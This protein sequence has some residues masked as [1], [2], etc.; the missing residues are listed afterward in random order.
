MFDVE[1]KLEVVIKYIRESRG[2]N[3]R[4][5]IIDIIKD[6]LNTM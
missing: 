5:R 3:D 2:I 6:L 1:D 4:D